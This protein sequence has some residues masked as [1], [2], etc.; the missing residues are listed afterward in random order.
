MNLFFRSFR[1]SSAGNCLAFWTADSSI[2][3]DCGVQTL[4][5]C[6]AIVHGQQDRH[7]PLD[8]VLVT[9]AHGDH[10]GG[11]AARVLA[12]AGVVAYAHRDAVPQLRA[13]LGKAG[14]DG[15]AL[16]PFPGERFTLGEFDVEAIRLPH[17]PGVATFG[18]VLR[19][20]HGSRRRK[21]VVCTDLHDAS[22]VAPH[23]EGA[24]FVFVEANH[25]PELLRR[26]PNPNSR[27]HL[28]NGKTAALLCRAVEDGRC[29]P[30][31][32]VLGHLSEQRNR[33]SLATGEVERA[34]A[35]RG[36]DM[37]FA[38]ETAPKFEP[39]RAIRIE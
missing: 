24:D 32:V 3:V 10:L 30:A 35:R 1:S 17:A 31:R 7:G 18:F 13:R 28:S 29:S 4:G 23:L 16:R 20:G 12:E 14:A 27:Y 11:P 22:A 19:V 37:P 36:L 34:F 21:V 39:S 33:D 38:L 25:D 8:G 6:R 26:H 5:D 2:L 15:R 9:H